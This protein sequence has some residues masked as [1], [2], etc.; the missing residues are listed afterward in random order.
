MQKQYDRSIEYYQKASNNSIQVPYGLALSH[1][2]SGNHRAS[3]RLLK[4]IAGYNSRTPSF[5]P[6]VVTHK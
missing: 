5:E 6:V 3:Q 2:G 4:Q 1:Q